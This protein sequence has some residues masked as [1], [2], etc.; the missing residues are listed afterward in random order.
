[1]FFPNRGAHIRLTRLLGSLLLSLFLLA[2][3]ARVA[4]AWDIWL[5]TNQHRV[6]VI[7]DVDGAPHQE[8]VLTHQP[9]PNAYARAFGDVAFAGD[10]ALYG[11]SLTLGRRSSLY[12]IDV[13]SGAI[14]AVGELPFEW[15]N[16]LYFDPRTNRAYTGGGLQSWSP[17]R[18]AHGFYAFDNVAPTTAFLWHDMRPVHPSGGYTGG[19]TQA[20]GYLYA[21]WGWNNSLDH[22]AFLFEITTDASQ[23]FV[24]GVNLGE[25]EIHGVPAGIW[26]VVSDGEHLYALS[27]TALYRVNIVQHVATYSKVMD[28]TLNPGE[29]V[30]GSTTRYADLS[31]THQA[32]KT[33]AVIGERIHLVTTIRNDG[34]YDAERVTVQ[35]TLPTGYLLNSAVANSGTYNAATGEW[36]MPILAAGTEATLTLTVTV[37]HDGILKSTAEI[38]RASTT[39]P[40]SNTASSFDVDD[41]HDGLP[42]DDEAQTIVIDPPRLPTSG[43]PRGVVTALPA[44]P[45]AKAHA[46]TGL[47]LEIPSLG[48][49][50][51]VVGVP[52]SSG[53]WDVSWLGDAVGWLQGT[54]FPTWEGNTVLTAHVWNADNSPGVFIGL[55]SLRFDD[56][57]LLHVEGRTYVYAVR[58]NRLLAPNDVSI[59]LAH[60]ERDWLTLLTCEDYLP[61]S[62]V[63]RYRRMVRAVL[64]A[65]R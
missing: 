2:A 42:D 7:R 31:I 21:I 30:Y 23:N 15:G 19:Y 64:V 53:G 28:F 55:K 12:R 9:V 24:S 62:G 54:A 37:Q 26:G 34:P 59:A 40:D 47:N 32:D 63:Y 57:I 50:A 4:F 18:L 1:M 33:T 56:H 36:Q 41:N 38:T 14:A 61:Q 35:A 51:P 10:G 58:E 25:S 11:V 17:Y 52:P 3:T 22:H 44:R 65:V 16:A 13:S 8:F 29:V 45:E 39:D 46:D 48:V 5:V 49:Q 20:N 43:F 60:R 6:L 27:S